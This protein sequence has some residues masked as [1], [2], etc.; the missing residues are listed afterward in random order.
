MA[1][2]SAL[3]AEPVARIDTVRLDPLRWLLVVTGHDG[4]VRTALVMLETA[5]IAQGWERALKFLNDTIVGLALDEAARARLRDRMQR[6]GLGEDFLCRMAVAA[7]DD[8]EGMYE[9][10]HLH[11]GGTGNIMSQ[12]EFRNSQD[13]RGLFQAL[14][15]RQ[16]ILRVFRTEPEQEPGTVTV[17]IGTEIPHEGMRSMSVVSSPYGRGENRGYIGVIGPTRMNYSR[18]VSLVFYTATALT[19]RV[20]PTQ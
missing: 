8:L 1:F 5:D 20:R 10:E 17:H 9:I 19:E 12:P 7:L 14:E 13:L 2:P 4:T 6:F 15:A 3:R 11:F 16:P 18:L